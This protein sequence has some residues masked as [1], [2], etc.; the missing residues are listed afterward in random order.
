V[1]KKI[2]EDVK[3]AR[4]KCE[5]EIGRGGMGTVF[6]ARD[7]EL[8]R[9]VAI[10]YVVKTES[11]SLLARRLQHEARLLAQLNHPNIVQLYD[12]IDGNDGLGL[13]LELV[14][15][16]TILQK[17]KEN[18]PS[19]QDKLLWLT[20]IARGLA[21]AH[22]VGIVHCDLKPDNILV[23]DDGV[24]KISDFGIAKARRQRQ[25]GLDNLTQLGNVSGSYL[26]L[27]PEQATGEEVD[28]RSDLFSFGVLA[29]LLLTGR[30]PFADN[31]VHLK[32]VHRIISGDHSICTRPNTDMDEDL[33]T[34][35]SQLLQ[36]NPENRPSDTRHVIDALNFIAQRNE[37]HTS[38]TQATDLTTILPIQEAHSTYK[39]SL[40]WAI[41]SC[42]CVLA[43]I[44][45]GF[46][47]TPNPKPVE[48]VLIL[49][50]SVNTTKGFDTGQ[51]DRIATVVEQSLQAAIISQKRTRL[52]PATNVQK[53]TD[54]LATL[55]R[56]NAADHVVK[57]KLSCSVKQCDIQ[58][59]R[60][61]LAGDESISIDKQRGWPALSTSLLDIRSSTMSEVAHLFNLQPDQHDN[62]ASSPATESFYEKYIQ[63]F[64]STSGGNIVDNNILAKF[65]AFDQTNFST[66]DPRTHP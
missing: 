1:I 36:H 14:N 30:H 7:T 25:T 53:F 32:T 44:T 15:G 39:R 45:Y 58:L 28:F 56:V 54:D 6:L 16:A 64:H 48:N 17:V 57:S 8:D 38:N 29:H 62:N 9:H 66:G 49:P 60:L 63:L 21:E 22:D 40:P 19:K 20:Q 10:K 2:T 51:K 27:S 61:S 50:P 65:N 31:N 13:T 34:L 11:N 59:Q 37:S 23:T 3:F 47:Q 52:V 4:Y 42:L 33:R 41:G 43:A 24:A 35:I 5:R 26:W 46:W 18:L 12:I 55:A